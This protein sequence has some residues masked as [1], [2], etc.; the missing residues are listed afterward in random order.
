MTSTTYRKLLPEESKIYRAIRLESLEKFPESFGATYQEAVNIEKF[1]IE[2]D[3]EEETPERFVFGAFAQHELV[4]IC[5]FVKNENSTGSI[6]QMYVKKEFQGKNIGQGL[7]EAVIAEASQKFKGIEIILEVTPGN[8]KAY[9]LY[10][11]I[12]FQEIPNTSSEEI[13]MKYVPQ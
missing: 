3:I 7:I 10:R 12:G 2:S 6:Y 13:S 9:N 11:K 8:D 5:T 4:G 1:R